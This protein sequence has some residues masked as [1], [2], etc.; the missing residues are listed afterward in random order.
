MVRKV[1]EA[2]GNDGIWVSFNFVRYVS[3]QREM[4]GVLSAEMIIFGAIVSQVR[5]SLSMCLSAAFD[6]VS[7]FKLEARL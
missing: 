2:A 7:R 1:R 3:A 6:D 4:A 5:S